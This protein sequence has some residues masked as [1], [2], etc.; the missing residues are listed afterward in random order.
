MYLGVE[1]KGNSDWEEGEMLRPSLRSVLKSVLFLQALDEGEEGGGVLVLEGWL[2]LS[3]EEDEDDDDLV[4]GA[5]ICS[6]VPIS[7]NEW[8]WSRL[9]RKTATLGS[10]YIY[11]TEATLYQKRKKERESMISKSKA[12][13]DIQHTLFGFDL[14]WGWATC[15]QGLSYTVFNL[16]LFLKFWLVGTYKTFLF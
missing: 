12:K 2:L 10:L 13:S 11:T 15:P 7:S 9:K 1:L 14:P 4:W 16:L 5:S 6:N 3:M 8:N